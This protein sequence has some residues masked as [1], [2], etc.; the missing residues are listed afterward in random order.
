LHEAR[1]IFFSHYSG[2]L[3]VSYVKDRFTQHKFLEKRRWCQKEK[4][5]GLEGFEKRKGE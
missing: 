5:Y 2:I 3:K 4:T 1:F